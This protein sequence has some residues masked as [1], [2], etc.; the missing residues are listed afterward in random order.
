V[1]LAERQR[2][3]ASTIAITAPPAERYQA[4]SEALNTQLAR[5]YDWNRYVTWCAAH[6][7]P[8][9]PSGPT[10]V[11]QYLAETADLIN[12]SGLPAYAPSTLT[13]WLATIN[14]V[15]ETA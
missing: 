7:L 1:T 5:R 12:G 15:N 4:R 8:H 2:P 3:Y 14:A 10:T 6:A 11:A 9:L 13:R